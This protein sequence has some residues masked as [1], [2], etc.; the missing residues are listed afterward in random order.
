[1]ELE[2][3]AMNIAAID[4]W[5]NKGDSRLH[6]ASTL[7]K[8]VA[9][10]A[11][12][13]SVILAASPYVLLAIY[14]LLVAG[15]FA[16]RLP[17]RR[18][19]AIAAYP[20]IF[21]L[22]FAVSRW[23]GDFTVPAVIILKA[24]TAA[25]AMVLLI[26]TTPYPDLFAALGRFL[27]RLLADG[28]FLTYRSFFLLLKE[29]N[30]LMTAL[31]LRGGL[32]PGRHVSNARNL[33]S[34]L[35]A[36]LIH[37]LDLS[38][39][40]YSVL[41][42]RGY[43]GRLMVGNRW[44]STSR[45]DLLP[46][47]AG[48]VAL[49]LALISRLLP[50]VWGSV[51]GFVLLAALGLVGLSVLFSLRREEKPSDVSRQPSEGATQSSTHHSSLSTHHSSSELARVSCVRHVY[52]DG[53]EVSLCGLDFVV[54]HG[55]RVVILGPN[56]A[57]K[58]TLLGHLLGLLR[59]TEGKVSVLGHDPATDFD[60]IQPRIGVLLQ[61]VDEQFIGPTVMD[62]VGF[63]ARNAGYT[64]EEVRL[65]SE[66][67]MSRLGILQLADKLPHYLSGGEKRKVALAGALVTSP[68]LLVL[69]EPFE[70]LDPR[71]R[72][73]LVSLLSE[74]R[75]EQGLAFVV[76]THHV[77]LLP[78]LA[79]TAYVLAN[80]GQIVAKG[81]PEELFSHSALMQ[82]S[83]IDPPMLNTLFW[84]L[85]QQ[86]LD[87]GTPRDLEDAVQRVLDAAGNPAG[88]RSR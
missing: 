76:T 10:L 41:R 1:V 61:N 72:N 28:L 35:G 26:T 31:R 54:H 7:G 82:G 66:A 34:A 75:S 52:P 58:S 44:R 85:S 86:G 80:G 62:D 11:F 67:V 39:R 81:S 69:D 42:V 57:G 78:A 64:E 9:A 55:E 30:M 63:G 12:V 87:L 53:T 49:A 2:L 38:Q 5:A 18:L 29:M 27:P 47:S 13:A 19:M 48:A 3:H 73:E 8:G 51:N 14:L 59:P 20:T 83:A 56:G 84:R 16:T 17:A 79:D 65:K 68:E 22:L 37:A 33:S 50:G 32:R 6:R 77:D 15:V 60:A 40:L 24:L 36:L 45:N 74:L 25:Q 46:L 4:Y 43:R 23:N 71:S 21:A 88:S 70:G